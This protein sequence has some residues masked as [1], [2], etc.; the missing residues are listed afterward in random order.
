M[1]ETT[2]KE[3]ATLIEI[4]KVKNGWIVI[5]ANSSEEYVTKKKS[6]VVKS[7]KNFLDEKDFF[8]E[9]QLKIEKE[10]DAS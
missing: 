3:P 8:N 10:E 5:N 7:V 2:K 6:E 4:R 9:K 1:E